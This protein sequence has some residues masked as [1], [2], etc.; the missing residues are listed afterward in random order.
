MTDVAISVRVDEN[1]HV[2]MKEHDDI[3]WS[4]VVLKSIIEKLANASSID[5]ERAKNAALALDK[6]RA[7]KVFD[8][9]KDSL[10]ILHEWRQKR[11]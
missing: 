2:Q 8:R 11:K 4:A 9:K 3:N 10:E 1:I 6:L 7:R 5:F